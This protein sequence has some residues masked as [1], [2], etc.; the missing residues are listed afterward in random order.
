MCEKLEIKNRASENVDYAW[1][2]NMLEER[3]YDLRGYASSQIEDAQQRNDNTW[4][5]LWRGYRIACNEILDIL[6]ELIK[7]AEF[8]TEE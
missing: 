6:Y 4:E 1:V 7:D 8:F 5:A 2:V 3:V